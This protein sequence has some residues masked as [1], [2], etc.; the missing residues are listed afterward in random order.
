M[1]QMVGSQHAIAVKVFDKNGN[2]LTDTSREFQH[3]YN[4]GRYGRLPSY[5]DKD[6][7]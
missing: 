2:S 1:D 5:H 3:H 4:L 7:C 6:T